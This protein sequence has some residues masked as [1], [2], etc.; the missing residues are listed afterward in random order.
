MA[1]AILQCALLALSTAAFAR[2]AGSGRRVNIVRG[3]VLGYVSHYLLTM[4]CLFGFDIYTLYG[5]PMA[6]LPGVQ[7]SA[8]YV[9]VS[10]AELV[11]VRLLAPRLKRDAAWKKRDALFALLGAVLAGLAGLL[12]FVPH[13]FIDYFGIL[14]GDQ[15]VFLVTQGGGEAT[16]DVTY[17]I[18]NYMV[19]PVV[20]TAVLGAMIPLARHSVM[21]R[22]R[23]DIAGEGAETQVSAEAVPCHARILS[24][25]F[26]RSAYALAALAT[27]ASAVYAVV[28]LPVKEIIASGFVS[29][30]YIA[31]NYVPPTPQRLHFPQERRNVLHIYMESVEASYY[32]RANGGYMKE[33]LMPDLEELTK[34]N[35]SFSQT[36]V[37]GGPT[38]TYG[39]VHS[40]A[41]MI[42]MWA[43][44][45][46]KSS[47]DNGSGRQLDYP[48]FATLGDIFHAAGYNTEF[49]L[50]AKARWGGLGDYYREHGDFKV[51]DH[52]YA[53]EH[54]Y[55]PAGY[56]KWW[57][58]EDDKLYAWAKDE[59]TALA[60]AGKPFYFVLENADTH[61]PD[62]Y[63]S[64]RMKEKPFKQQYANVIHFSQAE[65]VDF[66]R[67][68]QAQPWAPDTTIVVT[69]DHRSMDRNFFK[70]WDPGYER[71]VVNVFINAV[72]GDP[73][74]ERTRKR[75]FAPFDFYPTILAAAGV[76]IEG[77]RLGL[78]TNLFSGKETLLERDGREK[79]NEELS[80][81]SQFYVDYKA[82]AL[83]EGTW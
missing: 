73:G 75:A 79:V 24:K 18:N 81:F 16:A 3:L 78:G 52:E 7:Y 69:G 19:A 43:G 44:V 38:Q 65:V 37:L 14:S 71:S 74:V 4:I 1:F 54:G 64:P 56:K 62:G 48:A 29:S 42:N 31:D 11:V 63:V 50:G 22:T 13:W 21:A 67:W 5:A 41:A 17:Q 53:I 33:N 82:P 35:V 32:D 49:M 15:L 66:V 30:T 25:V 12:F 61:F 28:I 8:A 70:G 36:D 59:L 57:G 9:L 47:P 83:P 26:R 68:A 10:A 39:S 60:A 55:I 72:P 34:E 20:M 6:K 76:Q 45:P 23:R 27:V 46:M 40:I 58:Y 51:F 77:D 80:H 2:L